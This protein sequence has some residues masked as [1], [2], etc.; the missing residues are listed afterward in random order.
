MRDDVKVAIVLV[1][2]VI[3]AALMYFSYTGPAAIIR[4]ARLT[5]LYGADCLIGPP[6][7][8][9][10]GQEAPPASPPREVAR[11][12]RWALPSPGGT[13]PPEDQATLITYL[14]QPGDTL[15]AL[16]VRYLGSEKHL[17]QLLGVNPGVDPRRLRVGQKILIPKRAVT[18]SDW[19]RPPSAKPQA[20]TQ[21]RTYRVRPGE[22]FSTIARK[23]YGDPRLG[24]KLLELN[25]EQVH[26]DPKRLQ[27]GQVI[28]LPAD[29]PVR[30]P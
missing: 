13:S 7:S 30:S 10:P 2:L 29:R 27:A 18:P 4:V 16:A 21:R 22:S 5:P 26:G 25:R 20:S 15:A 24:E 11:L 28:R 17:G 1:V 14:V 6:T 19:P 23:L 12:P 9:L 3:T 8:E